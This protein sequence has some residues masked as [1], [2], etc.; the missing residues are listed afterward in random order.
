L[1][2]KDCH[3]AYIWQTGRALKIRYKEHLGSI[4]CNK[5]DS[6]YATHIL[7]NMHQ[8]G[9]IEEIIDRIDHEKKGRIMNIRENLYI[10]MYK[11]ENKLIEEQKM[12]TDQYRNALY[13]VS[14]MYRNTQLKT[15]T[16]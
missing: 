8:Y 2:C 3:K 7:S 9:N 6:A 4:R 15:D 14:K 11:Q 12:L 5:D 16:T 1:I 13:D 10:Y